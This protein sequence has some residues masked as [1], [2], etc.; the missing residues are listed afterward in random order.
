MNIKERN[1]KIIRLFKKGIS[2]KK[3]AYAFDMSQQ[4]V[5]C[6]VHHWKPAIVNCESCKKK[7]FAEIK[8]KKLCID[9]QPLFLNGN[10]N[11]VEGREYAR[12]KVLIRDGFTCQMC[13]DT[14]RPE[15]V[16]EHNSQC[17]GLKGRMKLFDVHHLGG[18]CGKQTRSY[19]KANKLDKLITL[20]H[21]CHF[22]H[23]EHSF[24]LNKQG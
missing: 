17:E 9:C 4:N 2:N 19:D 3:L 18:K 5:S 7:F 8:Q 16:I 10:G 6:I 1:E 12:R 24:N 13:G 22:N 21:A 11:T 14:R 23:P 15:E 20:C